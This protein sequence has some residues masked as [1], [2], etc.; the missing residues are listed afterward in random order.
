MPGLFDRLKAELGDDEPSGVTPLEIA[1][2]PDS[3]RRI[4]LWMLR[5]RSASTEGVDVVT[6]QTKI[7]NLPDDYGDVMESLARDGWLITMGES[8]N[9]R[10]KVNLRRKRGST[11]GF[12]LWSII[13]DRINPEAPDE[14]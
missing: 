10:Y 5:D 13:S 7:P 2:L 11:M 12:G 3:Q 6:L 14:T 1:E 8:P 9:F 4:M